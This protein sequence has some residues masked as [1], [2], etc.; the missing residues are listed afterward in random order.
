MFGLLCDPPWLPCTPESF[1][2][3]NDF[4][5][6]L[7]IVNEV[8]CESIVQSQEEELSHYLKADQL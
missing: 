6:F 1:F 2:Q 7:T 3:F 4:Y 5:T 8:P